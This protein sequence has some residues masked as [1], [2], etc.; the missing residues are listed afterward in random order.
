MEFW[1]VCGGGR[2][3]GKR[4]EKVGE[5]LKRNYLRDIR[6]GFKMCPPSATLIIIPYLFRRECLSLYYIAFND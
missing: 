4:K 2:G 6:L 1:Q 5:D 3:Q